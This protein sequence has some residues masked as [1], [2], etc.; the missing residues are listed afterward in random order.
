VDHHGRLRPRREVEKKERGRSALALLSSNDE[1]SWN[2]LALSVAV[3]QVVAGHRD[4]MTKGPHE[5]RWRRLRTLQQSPHGRVVIAVGER[6]LRCRF[7][8][9]EVAPHEPGAGA[10]PGFGSTWPSPLLKNTTIPRPPRFETSYSTVP[11][12]RDGSFGL[13]SSKS[14]WNS[15][16]PAAFRG[17]L[18]MSAMIWLAVFAGSIAK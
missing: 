16:L 2:A 15:T 5:G 17:A 8:H 10:L 1:L 7:D 14:E 6:S 12:P 9:H 13:S 3:R 11:L 4:L 18:S